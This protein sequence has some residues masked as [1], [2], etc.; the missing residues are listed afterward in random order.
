MPERP[1]I[2]VI[3]PVHNGGTK[4][5][6]CLSALASPTSS[7]VEIIIVDDASTD[8]AV[9]AVTE[10]GV[11]LLRLAQRSGPAAARNYG[12]REAVGEI[13][14]FVDADVVVRPDTIERVARAF[15]RD[16]G[17]AAL[18]GSYDDDPA[19]KNFLSQ[20]KNLFHHFVHQQSS[21][22]AATF[23]AGCGAIRRE[24]FDRMGGFDQS[25][26]QRPAIEDLELGYRMA[27]AGYKILLDKGLQVKHLKRWGFRSLLRSDIFGRAAPWS[28]LILES[29]RMINHL[30]LKVTERICA[31]LTGL[32]A[33]VLL[34]T[35]FRPAALSGV[36]FLW[37]LV[38]A[39]NHQLYGFFF[40]HRG[41]GF[42]ARVFPMHLLYYFYSGV[43]FALSSGKYIF[44]RKRPEVER[45]DAEAFE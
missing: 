20:Y 25:K 4:L 19:E 17:L 8:G 34:L 13:L 42:T 18:F 33:A 30:N 39:L 38:V 28:E 5:Q 23:W 16:P 2:S 41:L 24:I 3:V 15:R 22:E 44:Q 9:G 6:C 43:T 14:L 45:H 26:Y 37:V 10:R 31:A 7:S 32:S 36:L 12:A 11:R 29:G 27:I 21:G 1:F 35:P 40:R